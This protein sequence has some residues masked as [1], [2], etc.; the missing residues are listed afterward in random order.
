[1]PVLKFDQQPRA[2]K[3]PLTEKVKFTYVPVIPIRLSYNHKF[4]NFLI[5]CLLDSGA[6][7]NIFP[8]DYARILGIHIKKGKLV[9]HIGIGGAS[10]LA[11]AHRIKLFVGSHD[12][13]TS[14][15]F[16]D[17]QIIPLLGREGFFKFFKQV[18]FDQELKQVKLEY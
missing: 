1:M 12:F 8:S 14:V 2:Y 11:Y 9:E 6:D 10:L 3:D 7:R 16:S 4:G 13:Q 18:S 15:D 5:D 17:H